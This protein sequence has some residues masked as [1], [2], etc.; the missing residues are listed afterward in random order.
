MQNFNILIVGAGVAGLTCANLLKKQ[1]A[2]FKL[3]EKESFDN[4]NGS[5]YMLGLLPLGGRVLTELDLDKEYFDHSMEMANYEIHKENGTLNKAYSLDFINKEYGSYRGIGRK[6][7]IDILTK[8]IGV[9]NIQFGTSV[10]QIQQTE[11]TVHVNYSNGKKE[12]FDLVIVADG[13]HSDTRK[14]LWNEN[15]YKYYD[16]GW[17]G[18]VAWLENQ[19]LNVYKEYWG[20]SSFMGLYPVKN[21]IGIFLGGPNDA[22]KKQGLKSF[23]EKIKDEILPEFDVLHKS[24]DRLASTE[25]PFYWEFHDCRT[26]DWNKG[27]VILLGDSACGFLP[28]AGVGASMAMDSASAF[29]DE[30]SRTD[31]EHIE[32]GIKLYIKRQKK[33]V[34]TAQEDSRKLAKLM[35]VKSGLIAGV[36]DYAFRF[37]SIKQ[38]AKNISK[39]I[40]G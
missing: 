14:L 6:E 5:G 33:R 39:T 18:W 17:G 22:V 7:L 40:E 1:G 13:I 27:N 20:A 37:Y 19:D 16:T 25:N 4:F 10:T 24:L 8:N 11:N 28:T 23:A 34:E 32:Y 36:R 30:L 2:Q 12:I 15:E 21:K 29:V 3:I 26:N 9:E 38:L 31:K 35:F